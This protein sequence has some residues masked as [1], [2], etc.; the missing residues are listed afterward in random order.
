[1]LR[2]AA[3]FLVVAF[4]PTISKCSSCLEV[5][6]VGDNIFP[7]DVRVSIADRS[8]LSSDAAI[9]Q[10]A[11]LVS[12]SYGSHFKVVSEALS[13]E[14]YVLL[15]CGAP[16]VTDAEVDAIAPLPAGHERK[17]FT[18]PL[19]EIATESTIQ[20]SFLEELGV[21]DRVRFT[22]PYAVGSCWQ[23]AM[24]CSAGY[25]GAYG[26]ATLRAIQ[27][28]SVTAVL[29]DCTPPCTGEDPNVIHV[30]ASQ[31]SGPLHTAEHIK[32]LAAFFN[33]EAEA[34]SIFSQTVEAYNNLKV[35]P[36]DSSP[37]VAWVSVTNWPEAGFILS[38]ATYKTQ[39]VTD[40]GG[41][42]VDEVAAT[43]AA[44]AN[45]RVT[46]AVVGNP[47]AGRTLE[48][49]ISDFADEAAA[50]AAFAAMLTDVDVIIDETY[51]AVPGDYSITTFLSGFGIASDSSLPAIATQKVFRLDGTVSESNGLDWFESR[52]AHPHW[53]LQDLA[54]AMRAEGDSFRYLRNIASGE[55]PQL[56]QAASCSTQ[57]PACGE[58]ASPADIP[59]LFIISDASPSPSPS[60]SSSP[61]P[62]TPS[63]STES[64]TSEDSASMQP[65]PLVVTILSLVGLTFW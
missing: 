4:G 50:A 45:L 7:E 28:A 13:Q 65:V 46:D 18:I 54:R 24:G 64:N 60:P 16:E 14:Q 30:S 31:D 62:S 32:F 61:S 25:E 55:T 6:N 2:G 63:P 56:V 42:N 10:A 52:L 20:L 22:S 41:M 48:V 3:A 15:Q 59:V 49:R 38:L 5:Y 57:L 39:F 9:V 21:A 44:G 34:I 23:K 17:R 37:K 33:K 47:G 8:D 51:A 40:A 19:N 58:V 53:V 35:E 29:A 36:S 27:D 12:I 43:S 26:N 1:M 11:T